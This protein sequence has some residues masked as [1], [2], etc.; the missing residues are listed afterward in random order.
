MQILV[1]FGWR[2][3]RGRQGEVAGRLVQGIVSAGMMAERSEAPPPQRAQSYI[4]RQVVNCRS[5]GETAKDV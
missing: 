1:P 2:N 3:P 4:E 5:A